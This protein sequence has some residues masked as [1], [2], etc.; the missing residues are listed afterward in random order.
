MTPLGTKRAI[1]VDDKEDGMMWK[2]CRPGC[3]INKEDT[4]IYP[5]DCAE[6]N[7]SIIKTRTDFILLLFMCGFGKS[8]ILTG[9]N[10]QVSWET[11]NVFMKGGLVFEYQSLW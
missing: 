1:T 4:G 11:Q 7:M 6:Q 9:S 10:P 8:Y 3:G 5:Y 2:V